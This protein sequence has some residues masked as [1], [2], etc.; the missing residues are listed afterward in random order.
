MGVVAWVDDA[1]YVAP[2][3]S[4]VASSGAGPS[5]SAGVAVSAVAEVS[6]EWTAEYVYA[7]GCYLYP[8]W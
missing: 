1:S 3:Y 7:V 4:A 2:W 8:G 5:E 6:D